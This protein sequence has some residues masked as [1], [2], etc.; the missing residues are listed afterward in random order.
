MRL[1]GGNK[2]GK[3]EVTGEGEFGYL[4][5]FLMRVAPYRIP[6]ATLLTL[7]SHTLATLM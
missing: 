2:G 3:W 7:L 4:F 1:G 6:L 5:V